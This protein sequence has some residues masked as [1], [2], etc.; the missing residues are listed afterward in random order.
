MNR[1][2]F[3]QQTVAACVAAALPISVIGETSTVLSREDLSSGKYGN[4]MNYIDSDPETL[5]LVK[6]YLLAEL[7][8][9]LPKGT[10]YQ[11]V[12]GSPT[13]G[14]PDP[15]GEI[16]TIG[17]KAGLGVDGPLRI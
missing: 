15:F 4:F 10:P 11:I 1:R 16:S 12:E 6:K 8:K 2:K 7:K 5:P 14:M 13:S 17:W 9:V 3:L